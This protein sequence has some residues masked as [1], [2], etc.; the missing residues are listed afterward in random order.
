MAGRLR[1]DRTGRGVT[2]LATDQ[3]L[4]CRDC[5][6]D[7]VFTVGEQE[8]YASKGLMNTPSRCP[9]CRTARKSS[10][11]GG[12]YGER[13]PRQM[14]T[15][16]CSNC[17]GEARVPFQPRGDKPVYCSTCYQQI[18]GGARSGSSSYGSSRW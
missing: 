7:F 15:A 16:T 3:T 14:Y 13:G 4:R 11:S 1:R 6:R 10:M 5:G 17:G 12:S 18:G 9:E 2:S 8:F